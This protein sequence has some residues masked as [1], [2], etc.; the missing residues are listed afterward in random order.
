VLSSGQACPSFGK[1]GLKF[2]PPRPAAWE[3]RERNSQNHGVV[4]RD[5]GSMHAERCMHASEGVQ[6]K[7]RKEGVRAA[8]FLIAAAASS[9]GAGMIFEPRVRAPLR[10]VV[11]FK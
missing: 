3:G 5:R 9:A 2:S 11:G 4:V 10:N 7:E 6:E 8:S 1:P